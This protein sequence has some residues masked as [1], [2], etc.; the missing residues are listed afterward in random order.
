MKKDTSNVLKTF[1]LIAI[2]L[3][4]GSFLY[5]KK[6]T[7]IQTVTAPTKDQTKN[8]TSVNPT[9]QQNQPPT[10][11][12]TNQTVQTVFPVIFTRQSRFSRAS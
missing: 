8:T 9:I 12:K 4:A 2:M 5:N 3:L 6:N 1:S 10:I 11:Q 7:Q